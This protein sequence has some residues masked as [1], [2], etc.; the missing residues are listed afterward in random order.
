[1][2]FMLEF[3]KHKFYQTYYGINKE[4]YDTFFIVLLAY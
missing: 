2:S 1:M 4:T 3:T